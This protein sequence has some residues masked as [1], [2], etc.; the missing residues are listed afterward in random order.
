M[1]ALLVA[2]LA[3][4]Q[5]SPPSSPRFEGRDPFALLGSHR[6]ELGE[7]GSP[8]V[9]VGIEQGEEE[10]E[11]LFPRGGIVHLPDGR[12]LEVGA[13]EELRFRVVGGVP[14]RLR[15]HVQVGLFSVSDRE[16]MAREVA[17]WERRGHRVLTRTV[18]TTFAVAGRMVDTRRRAV[19]LEGS[20]SRKHAEA[21]LRR[22]GEGD[23]GR[24]IV[25]EVVARATGRIEIRG[26]EGRLL[27]SARDAIYLEPSG[28]ATVRRVEHDI[29]YAGHGREDRS[30]RDGLFVTVDAEGKTA[31]VNLLRLEDLLRGIVPSEI[32]ASAPMAALRAQAVAARGEVLAKIGARHLS[33]PFHLCAEQ[34]CQVYRGLGG[35]H[36]R[37]NRAVE[38][39][40]G[41][42]L[43]GEA[44]RL[45]DTVYSSTCGGH[46]EDADAV[47]GTPPDPHL[48]GRPD[49]WDLSTASARP[50]LEEFLA[51]PEG[52]MCGASSFARPEK[53]RWTREFSDDALN[54][55]L[56]SLGIGR[57]TGMDVRARG[58]SGRATRLRLSGEEGEVEVRGELTIRRLFGNLES[59]LFVIERLPGRWR[60]RGAGWGHGAGMC[61]MGAIGRAE[62]G[63]DHRSI[64]EHYYP[65][66]ELRRLY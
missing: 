56:A 50:P 34:H 45:V 39:T 13:G 23:L 38:E 44:G 41:E 33:D 55:K 6:V 32:F 63:A 40:R 21:L 18:G 17:R 31:V 28:P 2:A 51:S 30:Y 61:Q 25:E 58:V 60:F 65:G 52:A 29:G 66:S 5:A 3:L 8:L 62:R 22:I 4:T 53:L 47:W 49:V 7:D 43:F 57:I 54:E 48:R 27:D 37:T 59:S 19:L 46:T 26:A 24:K 10:V 20:G 12:R 42:L 9:T 15:H 64:L 16:A 35:E 11:I 36:A 1:I 14:A